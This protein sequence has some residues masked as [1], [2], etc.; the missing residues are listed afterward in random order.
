MSSSSPYKLLIAEQRTAMSEHVDSIKVYGALISAMASLYP[1]ELRSFIEAIGRGEVRVSS[2]LPIHNGRVLLFKPRM[3]VNF[4]VRSP[5]DALLLKFFEKVLYIPSDLAMDVLRKGEYPENV[6]RDIIRSGD[7]DGVVTDMEAP[8]VAVGRGIG[9]PKIY[10][11]H[12]IVY[13]HR[14]FGI[15]FRMGEWEKEILACMRYLGDIGI[16][17]KHSAGLG[18]FHITGTAEWNKPLG[19]KRKMMLSRYIPAPSEVTH[20]EWT[21]SNYRI[22]LI[23]GTTR[24]G[25]PFGTLRCI[26]EGSVLL[27]DE[28]PVG[29]VSEPVERHSIVGVPVYL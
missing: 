12:L 4:N 17:K 24:S 7:D 2:P 23:T 10:Y 28:E 29:R 11:R 6:V 20:I 25:K 26:T 19:L 21:N 1:D 8:S 13:R 14:E 27:M 15:V 5:R 16:S 18:S 22:E 9:E 3:P